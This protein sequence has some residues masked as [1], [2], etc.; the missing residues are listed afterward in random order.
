MGLGDLIFLIPMFPLAGFLLSGLAGGALGRRGVSLAS[1]GLPVLSFLLAVGV[2]SRIAGSGA[3]IEQDLGRWISAGLLEARFVLRADRLSAAM[4]LV[5][6]GVGTLIHIYST[7]YMRHDRGYAR[8]FAFLNLFLGSMLLLVMAGDLLLMFAGWEMVGLCSYLL[9]GFWYE[10]DANARAGMKA[11]VFNRIGDLGFLV[12]I[13][14]TYYAFGTFDSARIREIACTGGVTDPVTGL[15]RAVPA[16]L[17]LVPL[18]C[19]CLFVGATGK[20]AQIPLFVWL[21][22]AMAGPTPVSA[23]IHAATMVT[24]GIY[25][26]ARLS[27][28][29]AMTP[30][31]MAVVATVGA[32]TAL[33][34]AIAA[35]TQTDIKKALACSTISQLGYMVLGCGAGAFSASI[36]HLVTH[37]FFKAALFLC[38]GLAIHALGGMQDMPGMGGLRRRM[39]WTYGAAAISALALAGIPPL[40]GFF[41]KD[42][43]LVGTLG[44]VMSD[45]PSPGDPGGFLA[46][47]YAG[48]Y[49][50]GT[51]C[52]ALTAFYA[53]RWVALVFLGEDRS[54]PATGMEAGGAVAVSVGAGASVARG[55]YEHGEGAGKEPA[56]MLAP[57]VALAF[58]AAIGSTLAM[59]P[60]GGGLTGF[61]AGAVAGPVGGAAEPSAGANYFAAAASAAMACLGALAAWFVYIRRGHVPASVPAGGLRAV[62]F[63]LFHFDAVYDAAG[64]AVLR[65][66]RGLCL[67]VDR[68]LLDGLLVR[69]A[70]GGGARRLGEILRRTQ[71]GTVNAYAALMVF[72]AILILVCLVLAPGGGP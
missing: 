13:F 11:F 22:D 54:A 26:M 45:G 69:E 18:I 71:T 66:A 5:V 20:S 16:D 8:Y 61:L 68:I 24:A 7:G 57:A 29:Y 70:F 47:L 14:L 40:S 9:I 60:A 17:S 53:V 42:A 50:A 72:G 27:F 21:P 37:S 28:L 19:L 63:R 12:G 64:A 56:T 35:L 15:F 31:V 3:T 67:A 1:C 49:I 39:P 32:A 58:L 41:S 46:I 59:I 51:A 44:R 33:L 36:F 4:L 34:G 2:V 6:A 38:A 23:L 48:L 55:S 10:K 62:S 25:M 52:E 43:I 65:L 30:E